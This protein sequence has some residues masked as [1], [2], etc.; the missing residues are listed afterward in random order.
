MRPSL[1]AILTGI[2][3]IRTALPV[4]G[5]R[6]ECPGRPGQK[7]HR[8]RL[9]GPPGLRRVCQ[10]IHDLLIAGEACGVFQRAASGAAPQSGR[11]TVVVRGPA[12]NDLEP[13][14][15]AV[16]EV[17]SSPVWAVGRLRAESSP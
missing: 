3:G 10:G 6:R 13:V 5:F 8:C 11:K 1:V 9:C 12:V 2:R 17:V 14:K 4:P 7:T 15:P 16:A